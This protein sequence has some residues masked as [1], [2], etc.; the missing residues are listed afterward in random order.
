MTDFCLI[1]YEIILVPCHDISQGT[2]VISW[3]FQIPCSANQPWWNASVFTFLCLWIAGRQVAFHLLSLEV[4]LPRVEVFYQIAHVGSDFL[5]RRGVHS[6]LIFQ[7]H[8]ISKQSKSRG[9]EKEEKNSK[10]LFFWSKQSQSHN[11]NPGWCAANGNPPACFRLSPGYPKPPFPW[12]SPLT[13]NGS[14]ACELRWNET[15]MNKGKKKH[16]LECMPMFLSSNVMNFDKWGQSAYSKKGNK[17]IAVINTWK[18]RLP[19]TI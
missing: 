17:T 13:S 3:L 12:P 19:H 10:T 5:Q 1:F 2:G 7:W 4:E 15:V 18:E 16:H 8:V 6:G 14:Q 9:A 11:L